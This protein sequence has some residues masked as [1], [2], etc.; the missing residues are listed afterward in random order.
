VLRCTGAPALNRRAFLLSFWR[1]Q[2]ILEFPAVCLNT[3]T[4]ELVGEWRTYVKP[5]EHPRL[6]VFC[7]TL[8]GITQ[9]QVDAGMPLA[10]AIDAHKAWLQSLGLLH[11]PGEPPRFAVCTWT[12]WDCKV[13]LASEMRWRRIQTPE[14]L[15]S[16][17]DLKKVFQGLW[18]RAQGGLAEACAA[19][20]VPWEGRA[21]SGLD[22]ARNT[23]RLA[24]RCIA[25]GAV[26]RITGGFGAHAPAAPRQATLMEAFGA[27]TVMA[28][29]GSGGPPRC[30]CGVVAAIRAVKRPGPNNG[31]SFYSCGR[32][33]ITTGAVCDT[34][35]WAPPGTVKPPDSWRGRRRRRGSHSE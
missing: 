1:C 28:A 14:Y 11:A 6:S 7:K 9:E 3:R 29:R 18:P 16:W 15:L 34:F 10:A 30:G 27:S 20:G 5:S 17:I 26:L 35:E 25:K 31:R 8:T 33:T 23:A 2:E 12:D 19:A 32:Y 4:L 21:H 22:D 13:M 24:A